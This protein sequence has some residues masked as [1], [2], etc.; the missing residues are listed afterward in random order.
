MIARSIQLPPGRVTPVALLFDPVHDPGP[1]V[2]FDAHAL[3]GRWIADRSRTSRF[4]ESASD[5]LLPVS[6][7]RARH[8]HR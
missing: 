8:R 6:A 2:P 4:A 3:V 7:P 1:L 5:D